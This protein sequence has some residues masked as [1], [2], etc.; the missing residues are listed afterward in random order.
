MVADGWNKFYEAINTDTFW[1]GGQAVGT[2]FVPTDMVT[3]IHKGERITPAA[4]NPTRS[5]RGDNSDPRLLALIESLTNE[6]TML[7]SETRAVVKNTGKTTS[8]LD[9]AMP[10]G[11]ALATRVAA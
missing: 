7:R 6:V 3:K 2:D 10:D 9:R 1:G 8:L 5:E 4:F 11:D